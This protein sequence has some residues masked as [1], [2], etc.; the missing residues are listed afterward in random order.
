MV[1]PSSIRVEMVFPEFTIHPVGTATRPHGLFRAYARETEKSAA[2]VHR[3]ACASREIDSVCR[4]LSCVYP[5]VCGNL[6]T[7]H[8]RLMCRDRKARCQLGSKVLISSGI[9]YDLAVRSPA[10]I[11]RLARYAPGE[12]GHD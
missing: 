8:A 12:R 7:D 3:R 4:H 11:G 5:E 6:N 2:N 10:H 9:R 1:A